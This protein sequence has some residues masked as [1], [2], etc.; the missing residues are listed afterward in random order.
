MPEARV[1]TRSSEAGSRPSRVGPR[2][3][4]ADGFTLLE[5]LVTLVIA[6]MLTGLVA[7][8]LP[9]GNDQLAHTEAR[10]LAALLDTAREQAV[11]QSLPVAWAAGAEGYNFLRPSAR[12]WVPLLQSPLVAHAWPWV[13][14][15]LAA[16]YRPRTAT[17]QWYA[18]AVRVRVIGGGALGAAPGW[19]VFGSEPVSQPMR[20]ELDADAL[21]LIVW[22]NGA[23]PF[24]VS[25]Q[26]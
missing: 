6:A 16:D 11:A 23:Q 8:A 22:S 5:I 7:L 17:A 10:R 3:A 26:R 2:H 24:Q 13:G 15:A 18:G 4:R 19:L 9:T 25:E 1:R 21:R 12:G 20:V 14:R